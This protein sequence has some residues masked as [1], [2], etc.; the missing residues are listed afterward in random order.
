MSILDLGIELPADPNFTN[1][2]YFITGAANG[3]GR[4]L[5]VALSELDAT[6]ILLDKDETQLNNVYDQICNRGK[7]NPV[8]VHQDL[9]QLD[10]SHCDALVTQTE[11]AFGGLDGLVH[12][13]AESGQLAPIEH[14]SKDDWSKILDANLNAP[15]LLTRSL[16]PLFSK[17]HQNN[18]IFTLSEQAK[19][20]NAF[21]GAYGVAQQGIKALVETWSEETENGKTNL[22]IL[23]PG[24]VNTEFLV[25]LYPGLNAE[26]YPNAD[27]LARAYI[28]LLARPNKDLHGKFVQVRELQLE[29]VD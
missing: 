8:I 14:Y 5:A 2:T 1:N 23:D 28:Y 25:K 17:K 13:A 27:V 18:V 20:S 4:A 24:K 15:F 29:L 19:K 11:Q 7:G 9:C 6:V 3:I 12:C 22:I 26:N 16:I 10:Q 21:W